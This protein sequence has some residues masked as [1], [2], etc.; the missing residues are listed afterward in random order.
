M[1]K[2]KFWEFK[3]IVNGF[4]ADLYIYNEI[5]SWD[6]EDVTSASSFKQELDN[7]G[8]VKNINLYVN[9]PG[10]SV[11]DGLT[12]ASLIAR[13][14]AY[15]TAYVDGMACSIASVIVCSAD[16]VVMGKSSLLMIHNALSGG[17]MFDN[18]KGYRKL[19][20]DLDKVTASLR[21]MYLSKAKDKLTEDKLIE[22]M[23][24]ESWL[25]AKE[26]MELGLCDEILDTNK[27][28]AK[29]PMK[30]INKY[31][32]IPK[33]LLNQDKEGKEL[34]KEVKVDEVVST[35]ETVMV[36]D[37][38]TDEVVIE[39]TQAVEE[40]V[41]TEDI[42]EEDTESVVETEDTSEARIVNLENKLNESNQKII[43]LT[44]KI[45]ELQPIVDKYNQEIEA[46]TKVENEIK[47]TEKR[48]YY[49]NKFEQLG[50]KAKFESEEIQNL[51]SNC[52][53][54]ESALLKLNTI[55]VEMI[56]VDNK[57]VTKDRVETVS[58]IENLIPDVDG[59]SKYGFK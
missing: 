44:D 17:F 6:D 30:F 12:I 45:I 25:G 58:K 48:D 1:A 47:L 7:V 31:V 34:E 51:L 8:D 46:K 14:P 59:A 40:E 38:I 21:Q 32:N 43:D 23:D 42:I 10:G 57:F 56:S 55:I 36:E 37:V 49:K 54:D 35:E 39:E 53:E 26:S 20:D 19:A 33:E 2:N 4:S 22:L 9:S 29:L 52:I 13:N 50:A 16:K 18:A 41:I 28:V 15:V 5:S 27:M 11:G 3:N 24:S